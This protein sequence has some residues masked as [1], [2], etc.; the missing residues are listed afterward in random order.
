MNHQ[1]DNFKNTKE[2]K[3]IISTPH[4]PVANYFNV[5]DHETYVSLAD[6]SSNIVTALYMVTD[7][8]DIHDPLRTLIRTTAT[9]TMEE[10]F[11]LVHAHRTD[12]VEMLSHVQNMLYALSSYLRVIRHNGFISNMNYTIIVNEISKLADMVQSQIKKSL[13]YDRTFEHTQSIEQFTFSQ[14]FF[15]K[16]DAEQ[17]SVKDTHEAP[18]TFKDMIQSQQV[19]Q[20]TSL[21]KDI[22]KE[23]STVSSKTPAQ[24]I[25]KQS[26]VSQNKKTDSAKEKRKENILKILKQKKDA[27]IK[28]ICILFKDCSSKTIQRDLGELINDGLVQQEGSRRWSTYNLT[29]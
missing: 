17:Y 2:N 21:K 18:R 27:S 8:L 15:G 12:R 11:A 9:E 22:R 16:N 5:F 14:D 19:K 26:V 28:D 20:K 13:P 1:K 4:T 10:L 24:S 6:Q 29:Y 25:T 3:E 23:K 7:F